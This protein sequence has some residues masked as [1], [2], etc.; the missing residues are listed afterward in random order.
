MEKDQLT[1]YI[2]TWNVKYPYDKAWR[3]KHKIPLFSPSH[4]SMTLLDILMEVEED[5]LYAEAIEAHKARKKLEDENI[6][7]PLRDQK[8]IP[9]QGNWLNAS[10]DNMSDEEIDAIFNKITF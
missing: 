9:G 3:V 8:Y 7:V 4:K 5:R 6:V 1:K 2:T 10:E